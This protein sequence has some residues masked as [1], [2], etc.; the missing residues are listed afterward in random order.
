MKIQVSTGSTTFVLKIILKGLLKGV[1][2]T[3]RS[4]VLTLEYFCAA[5][6]GL[7]GAIINLPLRGEVKISLEI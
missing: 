6:L 3:A 5:Q 2:S 1:L 7:D 4:G